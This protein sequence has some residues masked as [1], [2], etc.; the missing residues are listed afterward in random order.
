ME[1]FLRAAAWGKRGKFTLL[2]R[3]NGELKQ[4]TGCFRNRT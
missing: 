3:K 2:K 1:D 4:L